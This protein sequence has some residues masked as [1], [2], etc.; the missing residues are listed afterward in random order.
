MHCRKKDGDSTTGAEGVKQ[1]S[2]ALIISIFLL[3]AASYIIF[4]SKR[5]SSHEGT[6][7][8]LMPPRP[9]SLFGPHHDVAEALTLSNAKKESEAAASERAAELRRR[10][11]MGDRAAL[12]DAHGSGDAKLYQETLDALAI[13]AGDSA[14]AIGALASYITESDQLRANTGLAEAMMRVW[15]AA[16]DLA[17]TARLLHIAA[18]SGDAAVFEKAI[19]AAF[20]FWQE[21]KL[22]QVTAENLYGLFESEYWLLAPDAV[23]SGDGFTLRHKLAEMRRRLK[24][25]SRRTP[26]TAEQD[27]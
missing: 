9:R 25:N 10:A 8:V 3:A 7:R 21:G 24:S 5:S 2:A 16:P 14:E 22:P 20:Q 13:H 11:L 12:H 15:W 23:R 18:L 26:F 27:G 4:R 17:S 1:L 6:N 19:E